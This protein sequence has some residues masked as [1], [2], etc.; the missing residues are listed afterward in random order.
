[1][2][3]FNT[4]GTMGDSFTNCCKLYDIKEEITLYHH[5][6]YPEFNNTIREIYSLIPNI[7]KIIFIN[8]KRYSYNSEHPYPY[9]YSQSK[10][11][12]NDPEGIKMSY[13]P[14]FEFKSKYNFNFP[15][16]VLQPK[17][18]REEQEKEIRL[19]TVKKIIKNSK[20]EVVLIGTSKKYENVK[21][22]INLVNKTSLFDSF[23]I[24]QNS[25]YFIGFFGIMAMAALSCKI[26][27]NFIYIDEEEMI[28]RV[29]G[30]PWETYCK[31]IVS[32]DHYLKSHSS[33]I[34][35]IKRLVL[36]F[37]SKII[38]HY[39]K[40]M[41]INKFLNDQSRIKNILSSWLKK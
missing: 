35:K 19:K 31:H 24:V 37:Y 6:P 14:R 34:F 22:C 2:K 11:N 9:I 25:K 28:T 12:P 38:Y 33:L 32:L 27:C 40:T 16:I 41:K 7:V 30:T 26:N 4:S 3:I 10:N 17:S 23:K 21:N 15:Y 8:V 1:M 18:G 39:R 13:F 36:K 20:Y 29:Y 5:Q